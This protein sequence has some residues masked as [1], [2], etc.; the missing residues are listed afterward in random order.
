MELM[1]SNLLITKLSYPLTVQFH[2]GYLYYMEGQF[3]AAKETFEGILKA[4]S[5]PNDIKAMS[6]RQLGQ[7][8]GVWC[9]CVEGGGGGVVSIRPIGTIFHWFSGKSPNRIVLFKYISMPAGVP[10]DTPH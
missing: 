10:R 9:V 5:V 1:Y 8:Y 6:L 3:L 2:I 7:W 4:K